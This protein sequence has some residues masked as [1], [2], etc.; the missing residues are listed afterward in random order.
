MSKKLLNLLLVIMMLAVFVLTTLAAPPAQEEGQDYIVVADDWLSKVAE[1]YLGNAM[2]YPAI[3]HYTNQKHAEDASYTEIT[4]P[5]L[6]EVGWKIYIP[7]AEEAAAIAPAPTPA[8]AVTL[9]EPVEGVMLDELVLDT[10]L[11]GFFDQFEHALGT[12]PESPDTDDDGYS[13]RFEYYYF[14]FGFDPVEFSVDTDTDGLTDP[15]EEERGISPGSVDSDEDGWS[16]FDEV[17]NARFGFDPSTPTRD[18]DFDGLADSFEQELGTEVSTVDTDGDGATD[19]QEVAV[20][21]DPLVFTERFGEEIGTTYSEAMKEAL[22]SMRFGEEFPRELAEQLPYPE[23]TSILVLEFHVVPSAALMQQ[24]VYN[25]SF[26]PQVYDSYNDIVSRLHNVAKTYGSGSGQYLA[27][28]FVWSEPTINGSLPGLRLYALKISDNPAQ[29]E[30]E[31]EM[32]FMG[33]H[34]GKEMISVSIVMGLI[35]R[36]LTKYTVDDRIQSHVNTTEGWFI[37]VVN[38]NGY[39]RSCSN[40]ADWRKNTRKVSS[41]QSNEGVDLN[42][43]YG[44]E[45]LSGFTQTYRS[46]LSS[47]AQ[48]SNGLNYDGSFNMDD[49]TYPGPQPFSEVESQA[50]RGLIAD[51]FLTGHEVDGI[52]CS[53]SWHSYGGM[54]LRPM[55][56][57]TATTPGLSPSD[58]QCFET[59]SDAFANASG[60]TN[61][62]D[63][64][65]SKYYPTYGDSNDWLLKE[66]RVS[67][68]TVEAYGPTEG[69][70]SFPNGSFNPGT[71]ALRDQ[72]VDRSIVGAMAF[73]KVCPCTP[74]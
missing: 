33:A 4:D 37:P 18:E 31:P 34:H 7:S 27:R 56:H 17:L 59:L 52:R 66:R 43:N 23:I 19:F 15:F 32:L 40:Y 47:D 49:N 74:D 3:V 28:L 14:E 9:L 68:L 67:A 13:D 8:A 29:N 21:H 57:L 2:A 41:S 42:R 48:S 65:P 11:D 16:D 73:M 30:S 6:I 69:N 26:S 54:V 20:G 25:P 45:H 5:D 63:T 12:N 39:E 72:V 44:F 60:Y 51:R 38:P 22:V 24:S 55:G 64:F 62:R 1:K 58:R 35:E 61:M 46:S 70:S 53:I 36:L 10:D 71:A 50:V